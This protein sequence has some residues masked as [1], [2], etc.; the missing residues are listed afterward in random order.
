MQ[1]IELF[2]GLSRYFCAVGFGVLLALTS[3]PAEAQ[4]FQTWPE[5]ETYVKLNSQFRLYFEASQTKE[6][7]QSTSAEIGPNL[8]IF[9]KPL[10][11]LKRIGI[12]ELDKSKEHL[13]FLRVGYRYLPSTNTP[14]EQ[15]GVLEATP[16]YPLKFDFLLS[17]RNRADLRF[18][19]GKFSW[20]YRNR[21][22]V[23][24]TVSIRS[25]H[26][27]PFVRAEAYYDSN[28]EKWSRTSED[29]GA[30]F[31]IRK[32]TEFEIYYEHQNDTSHSPNRQTNALGISLK[33]YF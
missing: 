23:E 8:D 6:D 26:F 18:I 1:N 21:L 27:S 32:H 13:L 7:G 31:P 20:R 24:R 16:R 33:L 2:A 25:Y 30:T 14:T 10:F 29:I 3:L 4:T 15:R 5:I 17:D 22:T 12:F 11:K 28:Y 19:N 9:V